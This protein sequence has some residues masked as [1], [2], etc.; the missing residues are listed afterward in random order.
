MAQC[1]IRVPSQRESAVS[2]DNSISALHSSAR[3]GQE[4]N[5]THEYEYWQAGWL[6]AWQLLVETDRQTDGRYW[7][8]VKP[9]HPLFRWHIWVCVELFMQFWALVILSGLQRCQKPESSKRYILWFVVLHIHYITLYYRTD[10]SL[11]T[12]IRHL[13]GKKRRLLCPVSVLSE[14]EV[15][16]DQLLAKEINGVYGCQ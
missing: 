14:S 3:V 7:S 11:E 15:E 16:P 12:R 1:L 6:A 5:G 2:C 13:D 4:S 8:E 9:H 10:V